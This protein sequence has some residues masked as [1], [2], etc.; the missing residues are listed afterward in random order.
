[1][2]NRFLLYRNLLTQI[3]ER[4]KKLIFLRKMILHLEENGEPVKNARRNLLNLMNE[5][6]FLRN[7]I[8]NTHPL[9]RAFRQ[10]LLIIAISYMDYI[11]QLLTYPNPV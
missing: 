3:A 1:M 11:L 4:E 5:I 10:P 2:I 6:K 7:K 9:K 8:Q